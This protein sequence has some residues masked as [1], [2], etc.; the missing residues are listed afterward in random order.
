MGVSIPL[1]PVGVGSG[2]EGGG[3]RGIDGKGLRLSRLR[4]VLTG[5]TT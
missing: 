1:S 4:V 2:G 3:V 5:S